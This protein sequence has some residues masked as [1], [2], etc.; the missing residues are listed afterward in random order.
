M[1]VIFDGEYERV[2]VDIKN[3]NNYSWNHQNKEHFIY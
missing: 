1:G 2:I 3:N